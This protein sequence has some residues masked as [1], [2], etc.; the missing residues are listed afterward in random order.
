M[1][2][3][4]KNISGSVIV[5]RSK[6]LGAVNVLSERG[7]QGVARDLEALG[8]LAQQ[9]GE[10]EAVE[11]FEALTE[12]IQQASPRVSVLRSTWNALKAVLPGAAHLAGIANF[13][14]ALA[15]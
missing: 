8:E 14:N 2:D 3:E 1:G 6:I 13:I 15:T 9:S 11:L 4:F 5:N 10:P 7:H 12:E